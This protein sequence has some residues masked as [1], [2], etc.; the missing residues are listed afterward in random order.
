MGHDTSRHN[1]AGLVFCEASMY[2][3]E[4]A[5]VCYDGHSGCVCTGSPRPCQ[6]L[7]QVC[8]AFSADCSP[9]NN[10]LKWCPSAPMPATTPPPPPSTQRPPTSPPATPS[11]ATSPP[12]TTSPQVTASPP[13][14]AQPPSTFSPSAPTTQPA[15]GSSP[16]GLTPAQTSSPTTTTPTAG[17]ISSTPAP[18]TTS[19][20]EDESTS[21]D[22]S[23]ASVSKNLTDAF[24]SILPKQPASNDV[25]GNSNSSL[26]T[27]T[28]SSK[29]SSS[30]LVLVLTITAGVVLAAIIAAIVII[31]RRRRYEEPMAVVYIPSPDPSPALTHLP[32]KSPVTVAN[33]YHSSSTESSATSWVRSSRQLDMGDLA[34]HRILPTDIS[35]IKPIASGAYGQV[36]LAQLHDE[37]VAVKSLLVARKSD[38]TQLVN[39]V[40]EIKLHSQIDCEFIVQFI[41]A[42]WTKPSDIVMVTEYM[43]KGD[44]RNFLQA[45]TPTTLAWRD[46]L[47]I[48]LRVGH[49]LV[50]L[51]SLDPKV[52]H[53]DLK[54]RNVLLNGDLQA[55]VTDFGISREFDDIETM[56]VGVGTY[57]WIAPEVLADGHYSESADIYSFGV[58]MSELSTHLIPYEDLKNARGDAYTDTALMAKVMKGEIS[59]SFAVD[60]PDWFV[61]LG[62]RCMALDHNSRPTAM[63][64]AHVLKTEMAKLR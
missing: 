27:T 36:A 26:A 25:N 60:C 17:T 16:S 49:V 39:F 58:I 23:F 9:T 56:T 3:C 29:S 57:R 55:K 54:S 38:M 48:A 28:S 13:V 1:G 64:A 21:D 46:K 52:I 30:T 7:S 33:T 42:S 53:R 61:Q 40:D 51:H 24:L 50:Y 37:T 44:L 63:E 6:A 41:G 43:D 22:D 62:K 12:A 8:Q 18:E 35:I 2:F 14:T 45:T 20:E 5:S 19:S 32:R 59:P 11:P 15:T 47:D 4:D 31:Q 34:M 10:F